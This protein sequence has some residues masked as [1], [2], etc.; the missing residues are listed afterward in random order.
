MLK[1]VARRLAHWQ[2]R[3]LSDAWWSLRKVA[4]GNIDGEQR[5]RPNTC[6]VAP[7]VW[8]A[9]KPVACR[10]RKESMMVGGLP[11][12]GGVLGFVSAGLGPRYCHFHCDV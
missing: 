11:T 12:R 7:A 2:N 6:G 1:R 5:Q 3:L 9:V 8:I 4:E 10:L